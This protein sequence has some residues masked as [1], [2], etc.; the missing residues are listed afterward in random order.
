MKLIQTALPII[1]PVMFGSVM[2]KELL[3]NLVNLNES[4]RSSLTEQGGLIAHIGQLDFIINDVISRT[5]VLM[6]KRIGDERELSPG[7]RE[8]LDSILNDFT[9]IRD[10][11]A[12]IDSKVY[13]TKERVSEYDQVML[14]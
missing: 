2:Y 14:K 7:E 5:K 4:L 10:Q 6:E 13:E 3:D 9:K 11:L 8:M 1:V 12:Y